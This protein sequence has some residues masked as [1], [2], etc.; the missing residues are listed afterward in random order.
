[1]INYLNRRNTP[2]LKASKLASFKNDLQKFSWKISDIGVDK[3]NDG[4]IEQSLLECS[5]RNL[6]MEFEK[7][8]TGSIIQTTKA[9]KKIFYLFDWQIDYQASLLIIS[10]E[11]SLFEL[12]P[13]WKIKIQTKGLLLFYEIKLRDEKVK[14]AMALEKQRRLK[15]HT[16]SFRPKNY[17][18]ALFS[19]IAV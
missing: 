5:Y 3:N 4:L 15:N 18:H 9:G 12:K 10:S 2:S 17:L 8:E 13:K 16:V 6:I 19:F 14:V 11:H 7:N 1:M